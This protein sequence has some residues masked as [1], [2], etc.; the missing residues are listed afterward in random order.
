MWIVLLSSIMRFVSN[1]L[2]FHHPTECMRQALSLDPVNPYMIELL[3]LALD[4][5]T[6]MHAVAL[7]S[8]P[9]GEQAFSTTISNLKSKMGMMMQKEQDTKTIGVDSEADEEMTLG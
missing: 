6:S 8:F 1:Y 3:N 9:G 4:S 7:H 5:S 2:S